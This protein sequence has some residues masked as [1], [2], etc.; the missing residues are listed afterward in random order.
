[1][2]FMGLTLRWWKLRDT[3]AH[4]RWHQVLGPRECSTW[5][6]WKLE[7]QR[8]WQKLL[9]KRTVGSEGS[10]EPSL[11]RVSVGAMGDHQKKL[12][13]LRRHPMRGKGWGFRFDTM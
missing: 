9:N 10:R 3:D 13:R 8:R 1:M 7:R 6:L 4:V 2:D 12:V 11:A 5:L